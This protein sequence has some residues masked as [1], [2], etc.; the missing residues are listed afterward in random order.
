MLVK[1]TRH[2]ESHSESPFFLK[3]GR[4]KTNKQTNKNQNKQTKKTETKDL[5]DG[6]LFWGGSREGGEV[7][8]QQE[9]LPQVGLW[10]SFGISE[11]N[12]ICIISS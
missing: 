5:G 10:G 11:G 12:I 7:S 2:P 9:T 4:T 1:D 8:T 3:G 6:D